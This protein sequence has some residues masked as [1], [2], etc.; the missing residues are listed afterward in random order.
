MSMIEAERGDY[1]VLALRDEGEDDLSEGLAEALSGFVGDLQAEVDR[2]IGLKHPLEQRWLEDLRQYHG[3]YPDKLLQDLAKQNRSEMFLNVT[4]SKTNT[5]AAKLGDMLFPTDDRNWA[6]EPTPVPEVVRRL[7]DLDAMGTQVEQRANAMLEAGDPQGA[8]ALIS[9][10]QPLLDEAGRS[11]QAIKKAQRSADG[12]QDAIADQ[13]IECRYNEQA[14][15][16]IEEACRL[17]AGVIKGPVRLMTPDRRWQEM[18]GPDGAPYI[19]LVDRKNRMRPAGYR[20]DPW[21]FFPDPDVEDHTEG[22]GTFERHLYKAKHLRKLAK[23]PGFDKAAI[24]RLLKKK[25]TSGAP[26][27]VSELRTMTGSHQDTNSDYFHVFE[28]YGSITANKMMEIAYAL[29]KIDMAVDYEDVDPLLEVHVCVWFCDG[30]IIKFGE[31]ALD[32]NECIYG[33]FRWQREEGTP[34]GYGVPYTMRDIQASIC[35]FWRA[36]LDNAGLSTV[37]QIVIDET[38]IEPLNGK[39]DLEGGKIWL[40]TRVTAQGERLFETFDLPAQLGELLAMVNAALQFVDE[41]TGISMLAEGQ[42]NSQVTQTAQGMSILMNS[43]NVVFRRVVKGF[44]DD[45]TAPLIKRFYDW[46]MQWN[47]DHSI[48]GDMQVNARGSSVLLV[49]EIQAQ[50]MLGLFNL[51]LADPEV[52]SYTRVPEAYRRVVASGKVP[53]DEWVLT[54]D[55]I[56]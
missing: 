40:K 42:Q 36:I 26:Y 30:E 5:A 19:R 56:E 44:D 25:P 39:W 54:D 7:E 27:F 49:Q 13:L 16:V 43:T 11:R 51:A 55:E 50:N 9:E 2:R 18:I 33:M 48:K 15:Q 46:N 3:I 37:P 21:H 10:A 17:G 45:I 4:R 6:I 53:A 20:V 35:A 12:M 52:R 24:R 28:Y 22:D 38:G 23:L 8:E 14:R 34:W 41:E 32:T 31:Q 47:P 29:G 1:Q